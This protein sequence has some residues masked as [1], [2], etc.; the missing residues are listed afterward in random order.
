LDNPDKRNLVYSLVMRDAF[1]QRKDAALENN[2]VLA[3]KNAEF[4]ELISE[5]IRF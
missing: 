4:D 2:D 3:Y 1:S 5:A